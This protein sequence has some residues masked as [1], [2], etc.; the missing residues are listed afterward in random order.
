MGIAFSVVFFLSF[1]SQTSH[2]FQPASCISLA[3]R[4]PSS[5]SFAKRIAPN[6]G[7]SM[8]EYRQVSLLL[9]RLSF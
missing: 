5:L 3:T 4:T 9:L 6:P 1:L 7:E 2:A 8:D